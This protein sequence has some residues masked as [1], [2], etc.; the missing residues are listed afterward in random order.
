MRHARARVL[1]GPLLVAL[2]LV[3]VLSLAGFLVARSI[4]AHDQSEAAGRRAA[5]DRVRAEILLERAKSYVVGLTELLSGERNAGQP[6][7]AFLA[8]TTISSF[9]LI[10]ALWIAPTGPAL[11]A[12]YATTVAPGTDVS[13]LQALAGPI[14]RSGTVFAATATTLGSL[15]GTPGFWLVQ[16]GRFGQGTEEANAQR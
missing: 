3:A 16:S 10:D 1:H 9:D 14:A 15:H 5:A 2:V 11:L 8:G 7:F 6:R 4:V 12:R 13:H